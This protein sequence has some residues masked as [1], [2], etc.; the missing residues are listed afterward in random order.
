MIT[1]YFQ[2]VKRGEGTALSPKGVPCWFPVK[3]PGGGQTARLYC[4][5]GHS[6]LLS[7][8]TIAHDGAVMPSVQCTECDYHHHIKLEQWSLL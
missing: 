5:K 8:H 7:D 2:L 3:L 1:E 4:S 6:G